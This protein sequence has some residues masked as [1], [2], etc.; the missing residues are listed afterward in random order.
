MRK[1]RITKKIVSSLI[2]VF[3]F[4]I[5]F[6]P[7]Y[8]FINDNFLKKISLIGLFFIY[9]LFFL[10]FNKNRCLGMIITKTRYKKE[11]PK[12]R[13]L[14]YDTLYTLSFSTLLFWVF[15]P[16]DLF[17]FNMLILQLPTLIFKRTTLHGYLAGGIT[18]ISD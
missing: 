16:F 6:S 12:W 11:Y 10:L 3:F 13:H 4:L 17:L 14:L 9:N 8:F 7:F 18:S 15:F 1:I 2:N 5:I